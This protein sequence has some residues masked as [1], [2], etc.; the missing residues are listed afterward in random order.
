MA[1]T[2]RQFVGY[3]GATMLP[4]R[5]P[6]RIT[7]Y[8]PVVL[9][10]HE[11]CSLRESVAGY[12]TALAGHVGRRPA[13]IAPAALELSSA[14]LQEIRDCLS[15]GGTVILESG[16]GFVNGTDF[17]THQRMLRECFQIWVEEARAKSRVV[18]YVD[19]TWPRFAR[20]RDFSRVVP[21]ARQP[22]TVIASADGW[23]VGLA[24]RSGRG[25][26]IFLGSPLGPALWAGDREA[27]A[28]LS[29]LLP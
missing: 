29:A 21:L 16:A 6:E 11:H 1:M 5:A 26:L 24:R 22:G 20:I 13:V 8:R 19:F 3:V 9:D 10:L 15:A 7:T 12:Q 2:R 17:R 23:P 14:P 18:P 25:A 28:L 4:L 27:G